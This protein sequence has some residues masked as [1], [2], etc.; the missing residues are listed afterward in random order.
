M[1][2]AAGTPGLP[3]ARPKRA[4][5]AL[6]PQRRFTPATAVMYAILV[7]FAIVSLIPFLWM[8]STSLMTLGET[9]NRRWLPE[10]PQF[11]NYAEAWTEAQFS[12]YF[13]NSVI[14]TFTTIAG[15]LFTS[16]LAAYAFARI[17]FTGRNLIFTLLL[18]TLMIPESVTMI[19]NF[20]M[21]NGQIIPLPQI[22]VEGQLFAL[23]GTWINTLAALTVPF[24]A[25]AFSIFLLRQ[26]FMQIPN[27]LWDAARIDGC[28]H[29][30]FLTT[31]V[32]PISQAPLLTVTLITFI[33]AWNNFLWPLIVTTNDNWRPLMV[34]L[35]NFTQEAGTDTHLL[36][37]GSFITILPMM[38]LYFL[39]Q[40]TF[41]EGIAT[42][43]LK[44]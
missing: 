26:F 39:T 29:L 37:A 22:G 24:M 13:L 35:Y 4:S 43:G 36:M 19:P 25:S 14:I 32:L 3:A 38:I 18:I 27:D 15:M 44:G 31:I 11:Q 28:G 5:T 23:G 7:T 6:V 16:V 40:K 30:R 20:L 2:D 10:V 12:K 34:G 42:T 1:V 8:L 9:I 41:T 17:H 33:G 21:V